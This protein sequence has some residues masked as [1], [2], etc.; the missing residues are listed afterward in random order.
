MLGVRRES[1]S[2]VIHELEKEG[3]T[4]FT[5]RHVEVSDP[6]HLINEFRL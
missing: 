1:V 6:E 2:R 3:V 4:H 5:D